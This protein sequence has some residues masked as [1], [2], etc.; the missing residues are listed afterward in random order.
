MKTME[1]VWFFI[2]FYFFFKLWDRNS[3]SLGS[4]NAWGCKNERNS[5]TI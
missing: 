3:K 2:F 5:E 1:D 4:I